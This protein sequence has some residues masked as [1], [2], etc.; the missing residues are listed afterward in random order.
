ME[1]NDEHNGDELIELG[2]ASEATKGGQSIILDNQNGRDLMGP[3]I[4]DD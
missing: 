1:R 4:V 2:V 3:G